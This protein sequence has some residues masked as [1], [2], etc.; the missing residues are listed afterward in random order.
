MAVENKDFNLTILEIENAGFTSQFFLNFGV[1][2]RFGGNGTGVLWF[3]CRF[4]RVV[5]PLFI[6]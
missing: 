4:V 6:V 1:T 3:L 5:V 2:Q